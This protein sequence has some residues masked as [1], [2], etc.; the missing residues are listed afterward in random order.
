MSAPTIEDY[1]AGR[2]RRVEYDQALGLEERVARYV[3]NVPQGYYYVLYRAHIVEETFE[4]I[5]VPPSLADY[6]NGTGESA[7]VSVTDVGGATHSVS[8]TSS[9]SVTGTAMFETSSNRVERERMSPHMWRIR[10]TKK[11]GS[12]YT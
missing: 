11:T 9:S 3:D 5:G 2:V 8:L 4:F 7:A 1:F 12:I 6:G 10:V